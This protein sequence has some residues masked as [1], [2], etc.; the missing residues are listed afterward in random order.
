MKEN[1]VKGIM[2]EFY[3][4]GLEEKEIYRHFIDIMLAYSE[5]FS[6]VYYRK[7][8]KEKERRSIKSI[9]KI[10]EPHKIYSENVLKW[11]GTTI[12]QKSQDQIYD[13]SVYRFVDTDWNVIDALENA[14]SLW[15]WDYPLLPMD[16]AFY[17]EGYAWFYSTTHEN[18]NHLFLNLENNSNFLSI[19]DL[20]SV[21][22][23]L[24]YKKDIEASSLYYDEKARVI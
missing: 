21:G 1:Y 24:V 18:I 4:K 13:L 20:E 23:K 11:P 8:G 10:L 2:K 12:L 19:S 6:L 5:A 22:I 14:K 9:K 3:V 17:R 16:L 15:A 7:T